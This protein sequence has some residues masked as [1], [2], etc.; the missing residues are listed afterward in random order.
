MTPNLF[1]KDDV[2]KETRNRGVVDAAR[3]AIVRVI[4]ERD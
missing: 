1:Q 3:A 4:C 2:L